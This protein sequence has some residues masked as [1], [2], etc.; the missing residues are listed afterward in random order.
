MIALPASVVVFVYGWVIFDV[1]VGGSIKDYDA[2]MPVAVYMSRILAIA[3]MARAISETWLIILYGAGFVKAYAPWVFAGGI[4]AP[5]A[6]IVLML[7]LPDSL[8][9]Y[10]PP[11]MC[12]FVLVTIHLFGLPIIA[13]KC[14]H[15]KPSSLLLS[16]TRPVIV[17]AIATA[18]ALGVLA[19]GG[20]L[21]DLGFGGQLTVER[22]QNI[23]WVWILGSLGVFG[24]VYAGCSYAIVLESSER[25][26]IM[27]LIRR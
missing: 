10:A 20:R 7:T 15:I 1:W 2:I 4:F 11:A 22:G 19:I 26:R 21:D 3:L 27:N 8:V 23:D 16:L 24:S 6:S 13:G 17:T 25:K 18:C 14:L 5:V 9:V 12:A